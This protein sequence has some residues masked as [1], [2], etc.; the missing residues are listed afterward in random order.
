MPVE[1]SD[2]TWQVLSWYFRSLKCERGWG[3]ATRNVSIWLGDWVRKG[4]KKFV[5][6]FNFSACSNKSQGIE[7]LTNCHI[8]FSFLIDINPHLNSSQKKTRKKS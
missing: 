4:K 2:K 1:N 3:T 6:E 7:R 8:F 5:H